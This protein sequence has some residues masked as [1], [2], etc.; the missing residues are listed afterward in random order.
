LAQAKQVL[1]RCVTTSI[2]NEVT[3]NSANLSKSYESSR[4]PSQSSNSSSAVHEQGRLK[5]VRKKQTAP[6]DSKNLHLYLDIQNPS[7]RAFLEGEIPEDDVERH[8][9]IQQ[10]I[11][12]EKFDVLN[13]MDEKGA[14]TGCV[15]LDNSKVWEG[16]MNFLKGARNV[17]ALDLSG[18]DIG[19]GEDYAV[20]GSEKEGY[21]SVIMPGPINSLQDFAEI[22]AENESIKL[23]DISKNR[24]NDDH[25]FEIAEAL[26]ENSTLTD[27]DISQ[28]HQVTAKGLHRLLVG[29][30]RNEA[31]KRLK[32]D[33][34]EKTVA[35]VVSVLGESS[36]HFSLDISGSNLSKD[37]IKS[38]LR[39]MK[40]NFSV[41]R[42]KL[43]EENLRINR[44]KNS[45]RYNQYF[46]SAAA[47][48]EVLANNRVLTS[49]NI[50]GNKIGSKGITD[51]SAALQGN[52]TL[53]SLGVSVVG[54]KNLKTLLNIF[55][56][57][58]TLA[59]LNLYGSYFEREGIHLLA[60]FLRENRTLG[61]LQLDRCR[62]KSRKPQQEVY[63][64]LSDEDAIL[65]AYA[66]LQNRNLA[67]LSLVH[68]TSFGP[69]GASALRNAICDNHSLTWL[70]FKF[71]NAQESRKISADISALL[72]RNSGV[73]LHS[74]AAAYID[75]C[76]SY[77]PHRDKIISIPEINEE[78]AKQISLIS[79]VTAVNMAE[80]VLDIPLYA[81]SV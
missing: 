18:N 33:V 35:A 52:T 28:N 80:K 5:N 27:L 56:K 69:I 24:L 47:F 68:S 60:E 76:L 78:I 51:L 9:L 44:F 20:P 73:K 70:N 16:L 15:G 3:L 40:E 59:T 39:A 48:A 55:D 6:Q 12:Y 63:P 4:F 81:E 34:N 2:P 57:N 7:H 30:S 23:L 36:I 46:K 62:I 19:R 26:G 45:I 77:S 22:L 1:I 8:Q 10:L 54:V 58:K 25:F 50:S 17:V 71:K 42:L 65:L 61:A 29:I 37:C 43:N 31:F 72:R 64:L 67:L 79:S 21:G 49:I 13:W 41:R 53:K 38:I 74:A 66:L 14:I 75:L 32:L 11:W